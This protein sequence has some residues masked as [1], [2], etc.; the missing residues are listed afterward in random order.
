MMT[1]VISAGDNEMRN[2]DY[3]VV[4]AGSAGCV[5]ANR[6]S[7]RRDISVLLIEAGAPETNR[8]IPI[9]MGFL[10][11]HGDSRLRWD[12]PVNA[13][14]EQG[15]WQGGFIAGKGLGGSSSINSMIYIRGQSEDY[16]DWAASGASGWGWDNIARCFQE[17]E[18]HELGEGATRGRGGPL[19]V[20]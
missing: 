14:G 15:E 2:Y 20:S 7:E 5:L 4:G 18:D 12:F 3:I 6:L 10:K 8:F 9:P 19:S 11:A 16:D 13:N 17:L 1:D